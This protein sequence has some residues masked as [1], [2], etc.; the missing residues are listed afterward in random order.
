MV[1]RMITQEKGKCNNTD[2]YK[3]N[4]VKYTL[5][6]IINDSKRQRNE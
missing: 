2:S 6:N 3:Y 1:E 5:I 4:G